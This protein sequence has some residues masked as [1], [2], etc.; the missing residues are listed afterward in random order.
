MLILKKEVSI[1]VFDLNIGG[2]EKVMVNLANY[3]SDNNCNVNILMVGRNNYLQRELLPNVSVIAFNKN[4][5]YSSLFDLIKYIR[6]QKID[7]FISNVWPL[8][9]LTVLAGF[10]K[11]NFNKKKVVLVEHCHLEREFSAFSTS[12]KFFQKI[13]IFLLYRF[14]SKVVAVSDGVKEDLCSNKGVNEE[15][16]IVIHNPVDVNFS[17]IKYENKAIEAWRTFTHAKFISV[18]NLKIQKNY[19]YL[20]DT[21]SILKNQGLAFKH[22]ILG[23]GTQR[24]VLTK[25][26]QSLNLEDHISLAGSVDQPINLIKE[27]DILILSSEFEGFGL[28]IVEAL[29]A[30]TTVV[31]TDCQSG[32]AEILSNGLYGYLGPINDSKKFSETI[33]FGYFNKIPSNKLIA[34]SKDFSIKN[35]GPKYLQLIDKI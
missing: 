28:V 22:L 14:V 6:A 30:G 1:L 13:S 17:I 18:G 27:A 32:P 3:L 35:V 25:K 9:I 12:F 4:R 29:A 23:E 24:D 7:C 31:S 33:N 2:T 10:F 15:K 20:I 19:S 16:V 8:T 21:L 34:R 5:I 11:R 26:I